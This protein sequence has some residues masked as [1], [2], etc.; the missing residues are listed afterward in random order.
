[1]SQGH[2]NS[3]LT[4][5][6]NIPPID[7]NT[8]FYADFI[9][10][11][12]DKV[13]D[14][15]PLG[16][17][18]ALDFNGKSN[19]FQSSVLPE[20]K[21][22][23]ISLWF[24]PRR[25]GGQLFWSDNT[26]K[27]IALLSSDGSIE[28]YIQTD[29]GTVGYKVTELKFSMNKWN[30]FA[31]VYDGTEVCSY[32]NG[33]KDSITAKISGVSRSNAINFGTNYRKGENWFDGKMGDV[34]I[35]SVGLSEDEIQKAFECRPNTTNMLAYYKLDEGAG[36]VLNDSSPVGNDV[37]GDDISWNS[38]MLMYQ[39]VDKSN[40]E[41][42]GKAVLIEEG[43][44]NLAADVPYGRYASARLDREIHMKN[45]NNRSKVQR[46]Y[47]DT[48]TGTARG[49]KNLPAEEGKT[50]AMSIKMRTDKDLKRFISPSKPSPEGGNSI[51]VSV[52]ESKEIDI[53][54]GWTEIREIY[55]INKN[56]SDKCLFCFGI[57]NG[58]IGDYFYVYDLQW[59]EKEFH[60]SFTPSSR[61]DAFLTYPNPVKYSDSITISS[62]FKKTGKRGLYETLVCL[63]SGKRGNLLS[64]DIYNDNTLRFFTYSNDVEYHMA[65]HSLEKNFGNEWFFVTAVRT[66]EGKNILYFDGERVAEVN[67]PRSN[68]SGFLRV[69]N[70]ASGD[71]F[72][73]NI[74]VD[75]L[76]IDDIERTDKEVRARYLQ[77][78]SGV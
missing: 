39:L 33:K 1:M 56:T 8:V 69:G 3:I 14:D 74:L 18:S 48:A 2:S 42:D 9:H 49:L 60:T 11:V 62:W 19:Y 25:G 54:N 16:H 45:P 64:I 70:R 41:G 37:I 4:S 24:Y 52:L 73:S 50:Y 6:K 5:K 7:K 38:G 78:R 22:I 66:S 57:T 35:W 75:E 36:E 47:R 44:V 46:Y 31:L 51:S 34:C 23:T 61:E 67:S 12:K 40:P 17:E 28:W 72:N 71:T 27:A 10:S 55:K 63:D 30:H 65:Q 68:H 43:T 32:I 29:S 53:G 77:G 15:S 59:E 26:N 13:S 76:I 20:T 58:S 21:G